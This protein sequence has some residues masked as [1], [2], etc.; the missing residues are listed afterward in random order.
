MVRP[1]VRIFARERELCDTVLHGS[2]IF[3]DRFVI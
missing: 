1:A 2:A 3:F